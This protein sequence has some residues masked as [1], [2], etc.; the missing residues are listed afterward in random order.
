MSAAASSATPFTDE[1]VPNVGGYV[2]RVITA[3]VQASD[4]SHGI[5]A[6]TEYEYMTTYPSF[7]EQ[8]GSLG[9]RLLALAQNLL[10]SHTADTGGSRPDL[11][12]ILDV[13]DA[14]D[15]YEMVADVVDTLVER[16]V[17]RVCSG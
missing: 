12:S 13:A 2:Q 5:P 17:R 1:T 6:G 7:K 10:N 4:L 3:L 8:M 9:G 14:D 11:N 16:V 15:E